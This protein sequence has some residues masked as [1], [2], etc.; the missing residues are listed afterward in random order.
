MNTGDNYYSEEFDEKII[1]N[2]VFKKTVDVT[3]IKRPGSVFEKSSRK[4]REN[5]ED[6]LSILLNFY[7]LIKF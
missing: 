2:N 6:V 5:K 3:Y 7:K 1:I 4:T